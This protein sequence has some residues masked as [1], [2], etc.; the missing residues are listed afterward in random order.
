MLGKSRIYFRGN[1]TGTG[2]RNIVQRGYRDKLRKINVCEV[3]K[4]ENDRPLLV[5][6]TL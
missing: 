3:G 6:F 1:S 5:F 4:K 2:G